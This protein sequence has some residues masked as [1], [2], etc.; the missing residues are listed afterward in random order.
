MITPKYILVI[1]GSGRLL[2]QAAKQTGYTPLVIDL[3]A[4]R[5]TCLYAQECSLVAS[6]DLVHLIP[7]VEN[8]LSRYPITQVVYG[9][10][11]ENHTKSLC[12]LA[13]RFIMYSNLP[14][15][16]N[17]IQDKKSFFSV[18]D[19][20][21]IPYP[22]ISFIEPK[23]TTD[24][25]LVKPLQGHGG[26][27]IQRYRH[28]SNNFTSI[29][30]Q[31]YLEG[32]SHSVLFLADG[33]IPQIIGFNDQWSTTLGADEFIFSGI[34]NNANVPDNIKSCLS[35]WLQKIV[36]AFTL[37]GLN[38]LDFICTADNCYVLEINARPPASM[39]LYDSGLFSRHIQACQG[40]L[41]NNL[42]S[43]YPDKGYQIVYAE[44]DITIPHAFLWPSWCMDLPHDG[45]LIHTG[46]PVC[47]II[48][49]HQ[50]SQPVLQQL[51]MKRH[52]I[53]DQLDTG[54]T[55]GI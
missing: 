17:K 20:L 38:S 19:D 5:D 29:Y 48:A 12:Y 13:N 55:H 1:A 27:G 39:Q 14:D 10:G 4:D 46:Q 16:F 53:I 23:N 24:T 30:W 25:W 9:S 26:V 7:T 40:R 28:T 43:H 33:K 21:N 54:V 50:P 34:S 47:S 11:F 3:Y 22:Q 44:R 52:I 51:Q 36:P 32:T 2:A 31:R 18:L 37:R 41:N 35:D 8:L 42:P 45:A 49:T 15:V 6:L